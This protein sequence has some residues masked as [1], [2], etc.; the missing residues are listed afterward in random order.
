MEK[1]IPVTVIKDLSETD[2][3]MK[4]LKASGIFTAEITFRTECAEQAIRSAVENHPD[5]CIGAGTVTDA[6]TCR[7]AVA[8]G[9]AFI[10][11][12]GLSAAVAEVCLQCGVPYYPGCATPTEIM[13]ALDLGLSTVKF[14]PA[15]VYGGTKAVRSFMSVFPQVRFIPTGGVDAENEAGYLALPNVAAVGGTYLVADALRRYGGYDA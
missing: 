1:R 4:A 6:E 8:A 11:S 14:F 2:R 3:I 5:M 13:A 9:A 7:K 12:P 10:V 15:D